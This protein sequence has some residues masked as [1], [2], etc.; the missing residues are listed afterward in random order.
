M[1]ERGRFSGPPENNTMKK[2][3]TGAVLLLLCHHKNRVSYVCTAGLAWVHAEF[4]PL[5][6]CTFHFLTIVRYPGE[7]QTRPRS[8]S[9]PPARQGGHQS[10]FFRH[11]VRGLLWGGDVAPQRYRGKP[12]GAREWQLFCGYI[13]TKTNSKI[14]FDIT[15]T[16]TEEHYIIRT[17]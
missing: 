2:A 13:I 17:R 6:C 9:T 15:T 3:S 7:R 10:P 1:P 12:S 16:T 14:H 4:I 5:S 8:L 11:R